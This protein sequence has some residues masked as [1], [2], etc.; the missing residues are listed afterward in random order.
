ML[1]H[2]FLVAKFDKNTKTW[3]SFLFRNF[4]KEKLCAAHVDE[5]GYIWLQFNCSN[6]DSH[7]ALLQLQ[8]TLFRFSPDIFDD[9]LAH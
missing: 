3:K 4:H 9:Y 6:Y 7:G 8:D 1:E 5:E 2:E